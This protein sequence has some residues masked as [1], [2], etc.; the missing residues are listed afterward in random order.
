MIIEVPDAVELRQTGL[1]LLNLAWST[2][3]VLYRESRDEMLTDLSLTGEYWQHAQFQLSNALVVIDQA[4]ETLV[5]ARIASVSPYLILSD[6]AA[7]W[8]NKASETG[9]IPFSTLKTV[10]GEQLFRT[11]NC[12]VGERLDRGFEV[13]FDGLRRSR[14]II[15]H[16]PNASGPVT[17]STPFTYVTR[18][19]AFLCPDLRWMDVRL[20]YLNRHPLTVPFDDAV[21]EELH[22]ET[23]FLIEQLPPSAL[24]QCFLYDAARLRYVCPNCAGR[25]AQLASNDPRETSLAC[26]VCGGRF[27]VERVACD[28][29]PCDCNVLHHKHCLQCD[30]LTW[31]EEERQQDE[32]ARRLER[33]G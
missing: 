23:K 31:E 27:D 8:R 22:K 12:I 13:F 32:A 30:Q 9:D 25:F 21:Y 7:A 1:G 14:N 19:L 4:V 10:G 6:G 26:I 16:Q 28:R 17:P 18:A 2:T 20:K 5:K 11:H 15:M 29:H 3:L 33:K 24:M